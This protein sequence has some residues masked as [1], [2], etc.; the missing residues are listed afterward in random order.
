MS[1]PREFR[2][3][4]D[5]IISMRIRGAGRIA[6][7]AVKALA[8][9]S[10]HFKDGDPRKYIDYIKG[11]ARILYNSRPTAVSLPNGLRYVLN[12]LIK[13]YE[14]GVDSVDMLKDRLNKYAS[15]FINLS[16]NAVKRI[17]S[18]GSGRI[19]DGDTILTHCN[20]QAAISV[21]KH[22]FNQGKNI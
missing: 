7:S 18:L 12:K 5:N 11:A 3:I 6:R 22:A 17:G 1:Y 4:V 9:A 2:R 8:I 14:G 21:I 13:D 15:E 10:E 16:L 20:S 19:E